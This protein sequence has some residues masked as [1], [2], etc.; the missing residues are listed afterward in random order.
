MDLYTASAVTSFY[1]K[2]EEQAARFYENL[3]DNE[4]YSDGKEIF[5]AF[6]REDRKHREM[7]LRAYRE[8]ITDAFEAGFSFTGLQ[9]SDYRIN[10]ELTED[11]SYSDI[12]RRALEIEEKLYRFCTDVSEKSRGL[13]D[14]ISHA[15]ERVA[16]RKA[17]RKLRLESLLKEQQLS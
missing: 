5:L 14:D 2:L 17:D 11:L 9:E 13:L 4:K 6:A 1:D 16:K 12:L 10:T 15:F 7:V 8:V 3:A